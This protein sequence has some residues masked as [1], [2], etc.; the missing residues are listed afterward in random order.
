MRCTRCEQVN[1]SHARFC[2]ACGTPLASGA[3][4]GY[5]ELEGEVERLRRSLTEALEQQA[6]TAG[7][8]RVI[9]SSPTEMQPVQ[10]AVPERA[11]RL[12]GADEATVQIV[13]G[14]V[15]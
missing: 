4:S 14:G 9:S 6:A 12:C 1:P 3:P 13:V 2:F 7:I 8:L 5:P 10:D 15:L 11:D